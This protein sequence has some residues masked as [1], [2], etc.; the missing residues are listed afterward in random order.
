M[1]IEILLRSV[2]EKKGITF[3]PEEMITT[4]KGMFT[5]PIDTMKEVIEGENVTL[6]LIFLG[7]NALFMES[8]PKNSNEKLLKILHP[9][10]LVSMR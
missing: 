5:K 4:I 8:N 6:S 1:H 2:R 9:F 7:I 3:Q 10:F